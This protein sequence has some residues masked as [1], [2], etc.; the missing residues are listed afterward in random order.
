MKQYSTRAQRER[1]ARLPFGLRNEILSR[2][3]HMCGYCGFTAATIDH[4][5]PFSYGGSDEPDNLI[6]CCALC[7]SIL[8]DRVFETLA[9]KRAFLRDRYG[10]FLLG[11]LKRYR[12]PLSICADCGHVYQPAIKNATNILCAQYNLDD[13]LW[14]SRDPRRKAKRIARDAHTAAE[15]ELL[16]AAG[17]V[18]IT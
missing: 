3:N 10:P 6:A 12:Q 17:K 15:T 2:D 16:T 5:V 4:I 8:N 7:N 18:L 9:L 11:R 14:P 13:Q 1:P